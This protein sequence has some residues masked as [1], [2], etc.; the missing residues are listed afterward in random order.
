MFLLTLGGWNDLTNSQTYKYSIV[1]ICFISYF[2]FI[3]GWERRQNSLPLRK[4]LSPDMARDCE[5]VIQLF[6]HILHGGNGEG[7]PTKSHYNLLLMY[8]KVFPPILCGP[9]GEDFPFMLL[10]MKKVRSDT[11]PNLHNT[12]HY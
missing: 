2:T 10:L 9:E 6:H 11:K 12:V 3:W 7:K 8:G 5:T 1:Q 4:N